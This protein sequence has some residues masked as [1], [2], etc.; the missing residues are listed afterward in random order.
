M[1]RHLSLPVALAFALVAGRATADENDV[2]KAVTFY[3]SFDEAVKGDVGGQLAPGTRFPHA[4]EKGQFVFEK[5][6]TTRCSRSRG[7]IAGGAFEATDVCRR[8]A[9]CTSR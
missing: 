2:R 1:N 7:G 5:G 4:T 8:T 9:A 6:S 3:A